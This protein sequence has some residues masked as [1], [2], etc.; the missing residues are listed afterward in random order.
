MSLPC[1]NMKSN[2]QNAIS[3]VLTLTTIGKQ[4][5]LYNQQ[6]TRLNSASCIIHHCCWS[7]KAASYLLLAGCGS[8]SPLVNNSQSP[9]CW[10]RAAGRTLSWLHTSMTSLPLGVWQLSTSSLWQPDECSEWVV[11]LATA[12]L[13]WPSPYILPDSPRWQWAQRTLNNAHTHTQTHIHKHFFKH[14]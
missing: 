4:L 12:V 5:L 9:C 1:K 10:K 6:I 2:T 3:D 14:M 11:T 8:G 13:S 7:V